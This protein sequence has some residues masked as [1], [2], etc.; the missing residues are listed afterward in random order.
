MKKAFVFGGILTALYS[1]SAI[2]SPEHM[3][4]ENHM[5][6]K[7]IFHRLS[8]LIVT[9]YHLPTHNFKKRIYFGADTEQACEFRDKGFIN[10]VDLE[11]GRV[12][13]IDLD[14]DMPS[15]KAMLETDPEEVASVIKRAGNQAKE[16]CF[17]VVL[18][19]VTDYGVT[20][21]ELYQMADKPTIDT[22][23]A[24]KRLAKIAQVYEDMG[25]IPTYK[26][27]PVTKFI[28]DSPEYRSMSQKY[29]K[30]PDELYN[31]YVEAEPKTIKDSESSEYKQVVSDV[32]K[33]INT[34]PQRSM[35]MLA[36]YAIKEYGYLPYVM[37]DAPQHDPVLKNYDGLII[38]D[39]LYQIRINSDTSTK[40]FKNADLF[41]ITS[42]EDL[43]TFVRNI[44]TATHGSIE[45]QELLIE[46]SDKV[47]AFF[48]Q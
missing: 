33:Q 13:N 44:A 11:G 5:D 21:R 26:H 10:F 8:T 34:G 30:T 1:I 3:D 40:I 43:Q 25:I 18:G 27:Y 15:Q 2:A 35:V 48:E 47:D 46:K 41:I 32:E 12:T 37:S 17:D 6:S 19:P 29:I 38:T 45:M 22:S 7:E 28:G 14:F 36:N 9:P 23:G 16:Q 20:D 31:G 42:L 39:D 24:T 4:V